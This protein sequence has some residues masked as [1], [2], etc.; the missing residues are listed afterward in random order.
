[1]NTGKEAFQ[2][3]TPS[4]CKKCEFREFKG[5]RPYCMFWDNYVINIIWC[6][7]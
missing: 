1:M 7:K 5:R 6:N 4:D 3:R 2:K